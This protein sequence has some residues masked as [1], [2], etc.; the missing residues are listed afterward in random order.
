MNPKTKIPSKSAQ[1]ASEFAVQVK[2]SWFPY[3]TAW[4]RHHSQQGITCGSHLYEDCAKLDLSA[5][6][7]L[8]ARPSI[9][10]LEGDPVDYALDWQAHE[11]IRCPLVNMAHVGKPGSDWETISIGSEEN[12]AR[13]SN[14]VPMLQLDL[15]NETSNGLYSIPASGGIYTPHVGE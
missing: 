1:R 10:I 15:D 8:F 3:L 4:M 13:R 11:G 12:L 2:K 6:P 14:L 7:R 9:A 5:V